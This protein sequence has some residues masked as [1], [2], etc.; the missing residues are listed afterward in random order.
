[1]SFFAE[2]RDVPEL[3]GKARSLAQL[4]AAGLLTPPG[5]AIT[6]ELF[7]LFVTGVLP[8]R[9]DEAGLRELDAMAARVCGQPWPDGF[10]D[11]L[12]AQLARVG[13]SRWSVRS[14]FA[15][16]DRAGGLGAGVYESCVAVATADVEG[17]LRQVL[18]SAL[19]AGALAYA[20]AHDMEPAAP[21]VAVL[22]HAYTAGEAEGSAAWAPDMTEPLVWVR[23]GVL[24]DQVAKRL[25]HAVASLGQRRGAVE[26]E[27]VVSGDE[28]VFLQLRPYQPPAPPAP[29]AGWNDLGSRARA[30]WKWDAAHNPLPL[31]PAQ[32][33][34]VAL[35]DVCRVG[36]RQRL[37]GGYLFYASDPQSAGPELSFS[38]AER[39]FAELRAHTEEALRRSPALDEALSL[40]VRVHETIL[41]AVQPALRRQ[42]SQLARLVSE[43]APALAPDL[44]ALYEGVESLAAER[45]RRAAAVRSSQ[46]SQALP[47]LI[48]APSRA[49]A[50]AAYLDL[51]GDESAIWDVA[52][53]THREQP[54]TLFAAS[55]ASANAGTVP[56]WSNVATR[57]EGELPANLRSEW[58]T[59][60]AEARRA[61]ALGEDDDWLYARAQAAVRRALLGVGHDLVCSGA[62]DKAQ[63][64][65][66]L[67]LPRVRE[68]VREST[69][70]DLHADLRALAASARGEWER[71]SRNPPP[72]PAVAGAA[73]GAAVVR[74]AGTAGRALGR[75]FVYRSGQAQSIPVGAVVVAQ[76]LL[77][78]ELPLIEAIALVTEVGGPLDHVAAQARERGL[79]AV[80]GAA[81]ALAALADGDLALVDADHGLVVRVVNR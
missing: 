44:P 49:R 77:P 18:A 54:D 26:V 28:A 15:T 62:L 75:V 78:T 45:H 46:A 50:I 16:E 58:R 5:F 38:E 64:V 23:A 73:W 55:H 34:L 6:D 79:P 20:L 25:R 36:F 53:P 17:A 52:Q 68:L 74:G 60:L 39:C 65:F 66:W 24:A 63:D 14:S 48:D 71:A 80:V 37:L 7:R 57:V 30:G 33:G 41:G 22:V 59:C 3:G 51:F 76:T 35:T 21:P 70:A 10:S 81:G 4:A 40:F 61:A 42:R 32:A 69:P 2:I 31:S 56:T 12:Q 8:A 43:H 72:G 11:E 27:W 1:M 19:S 13:A 29:W 47:A 9:L 67:P